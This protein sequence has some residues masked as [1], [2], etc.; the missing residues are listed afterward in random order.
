MPLDESLLHHISED[1]VAALRRKGIK[2][3]QST[4]A[5]GYSARHQNI[6]FK[7]FRIDVASGMGVRIYVY[8]GNVSMGNARIGCVK[9]GCQNAF[10]NPP[11]FSPVE[12]E[13]FYFLV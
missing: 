13:N 11:P 10:D 8:R 12:R 2:A 4:L 7:S 3:L 6:K 9:N 5:V 1:P